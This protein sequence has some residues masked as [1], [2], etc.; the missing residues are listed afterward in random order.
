M[1]A[2]MLVHGGWH[3][4]WCWKDLVAQLEVRGHEAYA[5]S[6]TGLAERAHLIDA[7]DGPMGWPLLHDADYGAG[8]LY[9]WTIPDNPAD[10]YAWIDL[11]G[12][13]VFAGQGTETLLGVDMDRRNTVA[14]AV[15][16][17]TRSLWR[18]DGDPAGRLGQPRHRGGG[19]MADQ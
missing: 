8:H 16:E 1:T 17:R 7:V 2:F 3:G 6:P 18:G 14:M 13:G 5:P 11:N 19:Q 12:D 9:V 4:G 15:I 10:L